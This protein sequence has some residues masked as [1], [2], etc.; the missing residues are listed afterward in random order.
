MNLNFSCILS[1]NQLQALLQNS[2][3]ADLD[4]IYRRSTVSLLLIHMH[5]HVGTSQKSSNV[6]SHPEDKCCK[7]SD[8]K[9]NCTT[10]AVYSRAV[11][12]LFP[13]P[14]VYAFIFPINTRKQYLKHGTQAVAKSY[15]IEEV[16]WTP[17]LPFCPTSSPGDVIH[18]SIYQVRYYDVQSNHIHSMLKL[19][20]TT[21]YSYTHRFPHL[22]QH[23]KLRINV[24]LS[25]KQCLL[26]SPYSGL[27]VPC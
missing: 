16:C 21:Q 10:T 20:Q 9:D 11:F 6:S 12:E 25:A 7:A 14:L 17:P 1:A 26:L 24:L 27:N 15:S 8:T 5:T 18:E 4:R 19:M 2:L 13:Y 22:C 23:C 3:V